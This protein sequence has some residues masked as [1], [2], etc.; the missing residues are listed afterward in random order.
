MVA[1]KRSL[2]RIAIMPTGTNPSAVANSDYVLGQIKEYS[3]SGL[4]REVTSD[5][6]FGG[7]VDKEQSVSQG[8]L[9]FQFTPSLSDADKWTSL[10]YHN[11][12]TGVY[13]TNGDISDKA[14]FI[15]AGNSTLGYD[16]FC[17]NNCNVTMMDMSHNADDVRTGN[18]TLKFA[19]ETAAG[20]SNFQAKGTTVVAMQ[21]WSA[22]IKPTL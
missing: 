13:T 9:S 11:H 14:V 17:F 2:V 18:L 6:H 16:A 7:F 20:I 10:A 22:L 12:S 3:K 8:E 4:E 19:P 15:E 1:V 5:P 21:N